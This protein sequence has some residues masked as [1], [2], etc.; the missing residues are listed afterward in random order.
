M[1]QTFESNINFLDQLNFQEFI[2]KLVFTSYFQNYFDISLVFIEFFFLILFKHIF[3]LYDFKVFQF[4]D[5]IE[6][7]CCYFFR[8]AQNGA[9]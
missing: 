7:F 3:Y 4:G 9:S 1:F 8:S 5:Q 6:Y 2:K